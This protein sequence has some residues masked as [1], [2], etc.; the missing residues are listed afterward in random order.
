MAKPIARIR[1]L[2]KSPL[3]SAMIR[4]PERQK[5]SSIPSCN[6]PL[7]VGGCQVVC[8]FSVDAFDALT[9]APWDQKRKRQALVSLPFHIA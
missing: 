7:W 9:R 3:R 8:S 4:T 5:A 2:K 1:S 6:C